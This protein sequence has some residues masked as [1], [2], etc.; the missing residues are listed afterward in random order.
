MDVNL[1][2]KSFMVACEYDLTTTRASVTGYGNESAPNPNFGS[3]GSLTRD[4][5]ELEETS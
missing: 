3:S 1:N 2:A 5:A 4:Q